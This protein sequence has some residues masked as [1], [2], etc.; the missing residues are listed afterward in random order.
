MYGQSQKHGPYQKHP[1]TISSLPLLSVSQGPCVV[2]SK[3][4]PETPRAFCS[5][6]SSIPSQPTLTYHLPW[7]LQVLHVPGPSSASQR[8]KRKERDREKACSGIVQLFDTAPRLEANPLH[9]LWQLFTSRLDAI[10]LSVLIAL[11]ASSRRHL[12]LS[13][14]RQTTS[15]IIMAPP[16]KPVPAAEH[17]IDRTPEYED[18][19]NKLREF[20]TQRGTKFDPEPKVGYGQ[21]DLLKVFNYVVKNGGYD[22]VSDAKLLWRH[23]ALELGLSSHNL[24]SIGFNLKTAYYKNLAA[25]EIRTIHNKTPPPPEI[26]EDVTA[27]GSGLLTRTLENFRPRDRSTAQ[28]SPQP[29]GDDGTPARDSKPDDTPSSGRAARGLRQAPPQRVIFQPDTGPTRPSRHSSAQH[30]AT[31]AASNSHGAQHSQP[32]APSTSQS[33]GHVQPHPMGRLPAHQMTPAAQGQASQPLTARGGASASF[34]PQNFE[35]HSST[36]TAYQ[37]PAPQPLALRPVET[38]ANAP[39]K[40]A[41]IHPSAVPPAPRQAPARGS[42]MTSPA[43]RLDVDT[44]FACN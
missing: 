36:V 41:K 2:S 38:P 22:K 31:P 28:N 25:Y 20:H 6:L 13:V 7:R 33:N 11:P 30:P 3:N 18:F 14:A 39:G 27:K 37:P 17:T 35:Y 1:G 16:A 4:S 5:P 29:S 8:G 21:I 26:L 19:I 15:S 23:V 42:K 9:I 44:D 43:P 40:F 34:N 12:R 10:H 24:D 32:R